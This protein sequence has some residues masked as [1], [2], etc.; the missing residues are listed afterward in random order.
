MPAIKFRYRRERGPAGWVFRPVAGVV[1]ENA[2][3]RV[4]ALMYIDSGADITT[5]PLAAGAALGFEQAS[6]ERILEMRGVS[7]AGV[8]Y[9]IKDIHLLFDGLRIGARVAWTLVEEVPFLLGRLDVFDKF[10]IL[11]QERKGV[12]IFSPTPQSRA[13]PR[14]SWN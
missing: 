5:I 13:C 4:E 8:P 12:I 1:L 2:P 14:I 10:D 3:R 9:L 7:G 11:F 6:G